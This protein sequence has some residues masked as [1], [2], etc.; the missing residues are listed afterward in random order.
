MKVLGITMGATVSGKPLKDGSLAWYLS[1]NNVLVI[2]E[3]QAANV[4]HAGGFEASLQKFYEESR[5]RP[6]LVAVSSCCEPEISD[7]SALEA[8][9]SCRVRVVNHHLSHAHQAA[10]AAGYRDALIVVMDAGGNVLEPFDERGQEWWK[11]DREQLSV[12]QCVGGKISLLDRLYNT[13]YAI[14][15]GEFWRY[16]T[17]ACGFDTSTKA[18]KVMELAAFDDPS[19]NPLR[20]MQLCDLEIDDLRNDPPNKNLFKN[21]LLHSHESARSTR[22]ISAVNM[23]GWAQRIL[24]ES[25]VRV[26][27]EYHK[28]LKHQLVCLT[29]GVAL[30]CKL[31]QAVRENTPFD[32]VIVG[33]CPSD[34]GQSLGNCLAV[35][36]RRSKTG[37]RSGLDPFR[38]TK[39]VATASDI[40]A[41][42]GGEQQTHIVEKGVGPSA[43]LGLID[44]GFVVAT[45]CGRGEVGA[46]ALG[47]SSILANPRVPGIKE[48]LN[49]LKGRPIGTPIA[50]AFSRSFFE[51]NFC[52]A[53]DNFSVMSETVNRGDAAERL[54]SSMLHVD[55]SIRPQVIDE[56]SSGYLS[57]MLRH[58]STDRINEFVLLNTSFNGPGRPMAGTLDQAVSEFLR[59][60][61]DALSC[62]NDILVRRKNARLEAALDASNP[63]ALFFKDIDDF[64]QRSAALG[65]RQRVEKRERFLL[66]DNYIR[67]AAQGRKVTTIRFKEGGLSIA[68]PRRL[69]LVETKDFKQSAMEVQNLEVEVLGFTVKRFHELDQID[70]QRDGF[71]KTS[72]LKQT[73][74]NIYPRMREDD[75]VTINFISIVT[76]T[77]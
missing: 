28:Q 3:E 11:Y 5:S 32:E 52:E 75:Y 40:R 50:P 14:G 25:V 22:E 72:H 20:G 29:G 30:N 7:T 41:R 61:V 23:A 34:K 71:E 48:R 47:N 45:W 56:N 46:R 12:F 2:S 35:Q 69:P 15:L 49:N 55:G 60:G 74:R 63:N 24:E 4:K 36:E 73:L 77:K 58:T 38:G 54:P 44:D 53:R 16:M 70:A 8:Q 51:T 10:W 19:R 1:D 62:P 17:Y 67:W 6:D 59:L 43:V 64:H 26:L 76:Q 9:F 39:R 13:P 42:L 31:V 18:S 27:T 66:F 68:G 65:L 37:S 57:R 21:L 33:Y